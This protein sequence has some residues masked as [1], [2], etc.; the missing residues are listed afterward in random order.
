MLGEHQPIMQNA[1]LGSLKLVQLEVPAEPAVD[2]P[3]LK[4]MRQARITAAKVS[5][6]EAKRLLIEARARAQG[7]E[8][9][10][11]KAYAEA[12]EA[13]KQRREAEERFAKARAASEDAAIRARSV[14]A[15]ASEAAKA[16]QEAK[17][18][19]E[20]AS[21]ELEILFRESPVR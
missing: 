3:Q 19:V 4:E 14:A 1:I 11:K 15:E 16:A 8:T 17:R 7:L 10:Q 20:K 18:T 2:V 12:K 9:A 5:V 21:K 6:Q 13:E